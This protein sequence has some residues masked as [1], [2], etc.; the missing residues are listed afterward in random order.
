VR[1]ASFFLLAL[2]GDGCWRGMKRYSM[3]TVPTELVVMSLAS[4]LVLGD[5]A[6]QRR[7]G[8]LLLLEK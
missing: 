7:H 5:E 3:L 2:A 4:M 6:W 1:Y 8:C